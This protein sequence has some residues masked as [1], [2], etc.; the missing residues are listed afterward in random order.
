[1]CK[2]VESIHCKISGKVTPPCTKRILGQ[3][4]TNGLKFT[5]DCMTLLI[6]LFIYLFISMCKTLYQTIL[7]IFKVHIYTTQYHQLAF[8]KLTGD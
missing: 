6:Y 7:D 3:G 8:T 4:R 5:S 1:M 2:N